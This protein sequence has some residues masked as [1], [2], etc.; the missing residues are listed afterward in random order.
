MPGSVVSQFEILIAT[1]AAPHNLSGDLMSM[2]RR[3]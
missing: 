2:I 1:F 3:F